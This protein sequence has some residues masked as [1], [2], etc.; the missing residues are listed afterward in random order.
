MART[1][2]YCDP[3]VIRQCR[4]P[5]IQRAGASPGQEPTSWRTIVQSNRF[6]LLGLILQALLAIVAIIVEVV[7]ILGG[8]TSPTAGHARATHHPSP[9]KRSH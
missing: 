2:R 6:P 9:G 7:L 3:S 1:R 8:K 4:S 5:N